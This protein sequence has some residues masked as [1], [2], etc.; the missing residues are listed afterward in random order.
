MRQED[1]NLLDIYWK[2]EYYINTC[3][4]FG[5]RSTPFLFNKLADAIHWILLNN[6]EVHRLLHYLDDFLTAGPADSDT[7]YHNLSTMKSL[8]QT[9]GAP[10]KE[11]KVEGPTTRLTCLGIVLDTVTMEASISEELKTSLLTA[12]YSFRTFKNV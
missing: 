2:S 9:I 8:C 7:C 11:E 10:I 4:P 5:L 12:I 3:L 6:Y 1:W